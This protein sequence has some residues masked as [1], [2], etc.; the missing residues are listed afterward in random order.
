MN[1]GQAM[2]VN[3][4]TTVRG[5]CYHDDNGDPVIVVNARLSREQ[6]QRTFFHEKHHIRNGDMDNKG[7]HEYKEGTP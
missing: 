1:E 3:L 6:N 5:F 7:Y 2:L 4:P